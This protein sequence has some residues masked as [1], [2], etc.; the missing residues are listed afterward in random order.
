MET[1]VAQLNELT[2]NLEAI[3]TKHPSCEDSDVRDHICSVLQ[4]LFIEG[5]VDP[6]IPR[7]FGVF[8][9]FING[10]I[11]T[12]LL[13]FSRSQEVQE[14]IQNTDPDERVAFLQRLLSSDEIRSSSG[15][16]MTEVLGEWV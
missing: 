1:V 3:F 2:S 10:K 4:S 15:T 11:R 14:Y 16:P 5:D 6:P 9:P 12:T 13:A 7:F 8:N